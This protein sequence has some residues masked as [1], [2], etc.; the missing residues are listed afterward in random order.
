MK[1]Y[2][3][4]EHWYKTTNW[5]LDRCDGMPRHTRFT[6]ASRIANLT[7]DV[8]DLINMAI[9]N[10]ERKDIL[11]KINLNLERLRIFFRICHDRGYLSSSQNLFIQ[12]EI[13]SAGRMCGGWL[14]DI[15]PPI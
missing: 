13:N 15:E 12:Q 2:P 14:K 6:I 4:F 10:K 8:L 5:I 1:T 11:N 9:Y 7:L 3:L